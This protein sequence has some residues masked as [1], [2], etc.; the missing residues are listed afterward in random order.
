M[1][2]KQ[3]IT[4]K[5][6]MRLLNWYLNRTNIIINYVIWII[7]NKQHWLMLI[8]KQFSFKPL[9]HSYYTQFFKINK[10][11]CTP[12]FEARET[13]WVY[14]VVAVTVTKSCLILCDPTDC[15]MPG[16]PLLHCLPEF[17]QIHVLWI[18]YTI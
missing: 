14:L 13:S 3:G 1:T 7:Q 4:S 2:F 9:V 16:F 12:E 10:Y 6:N 8:G 15:S 17:A 5:N 11:H 18:C